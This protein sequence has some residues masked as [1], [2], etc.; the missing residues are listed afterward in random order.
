MKHSDISC[1]AVCVSGE[2]TTL[3]N[4]QIFYPWMPWL[5]SAHVHTNNALPAALLGFETPLDWAW[6]HS[7]SQTEALH[8]NSTRPVGLGTATELV[9]ESARRLQHGLCHLLLRRNRSPREPAALIFEAKKEPDLFPMYSKYFLD[10][11]L[12]FWPYTDSA[13]C[14]FVALLCF[15]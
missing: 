11:F 7:G 13:W 15:Q 9:G 12:R 4:P 2:S 3:L 5:Q 6:D 10:F 8:Q 14:S 1:L